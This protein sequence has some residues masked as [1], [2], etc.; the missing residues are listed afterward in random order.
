[1]ITMHTKEGVTQQL[2]KESRN[3]LKNQE[4]TYATCSEI[5]AE[6]SAKQTDA[7]QLSVEPA[8]S[9]FTH[10][11]AASLEIPVSGVSPLLSYLGG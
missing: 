2:T 1:M 9:S 7:S 6:Q 4:T 11:S 3:G 5:R 8:T 10:L